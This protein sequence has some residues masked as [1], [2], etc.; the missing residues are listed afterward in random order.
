MSIVIFSVLKNKFPWY[1]CATLKLR[2]PMDTLP[3]IC[4]GCPTRPRCRTVCY[5]VSA[6]ADGNKPLKEALIEARFDRYQIRDYKIVLNEQ[7]ENKQLRIKKTKT[8][9][10][11]IDD[12]RIKLIAAG[13][14][15][16]IPA[17]IIANLLS[18][19]PQRIYQIIKDL[20][21]I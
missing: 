1:N 8:D 12:Q 15:V 9:I 11:T 4:T 7:A 2:E 16:D 21:Y 20:H 10:A 18:I 17:K 19:T 14:Y 5:P 3:P 6:L 13:L